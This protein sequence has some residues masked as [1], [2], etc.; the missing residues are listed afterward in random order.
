[1]LNC[2]A[3]YHA[4]CYIYQVVHAWGMHL[5]GKGY[6]H[7][8]NYIVCIYT[9]DSTGPSSACK[10]WSWATYLRIHVHKKL[11]MSQYNWPLTPWDGSW[12]L[13]ICGRICVDEE[14]IVALQC[15]FLHFCWVE[16][17]LIL[18]IICWIG[19]QKYPVQRGL[20]LCRPW[21]C[22]WR[23]CRKGKRY[24]STKQNNWPQ[25]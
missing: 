24:Y 21:T 3:Q 2:N 7:V 17:E 20:F 19:I 15:E 14:T 9:V 8:T 22:M 11:F 25:M 18:Y 10:V 12:S 6:V 13:F 4:W 5:Q 23:F 1:M 16:T